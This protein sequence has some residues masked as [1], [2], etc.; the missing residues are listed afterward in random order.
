MGNFKFKIGKGTDDWWAKHS[1]DELKTINTP[2]PTMTGTI[3]NFLSGLTL[4]FKFT[5]SGRR[6]KK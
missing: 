2:K 4:G 5:F 1:F 3:K 6:K